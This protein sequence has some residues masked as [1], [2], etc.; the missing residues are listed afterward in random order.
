MYTQARA[1]ATRV[2][3]TADFCTHSIQGKELY[4]NLFKCIIYCCAEK[5]NLFTN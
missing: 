3:R 2:R 4:F 5:N 1:T